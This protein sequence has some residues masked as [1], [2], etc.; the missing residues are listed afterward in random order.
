M[1]ILTN[2][3]TL[4]IVVPFRNEKKILASVVAGHASLSRA[5]VEFLYV[6]D[7][8]T[9]GSGEELR[10]L[11]PEAKI[12]R[13]EG[14]GTGKAFFEGSQRAI[15]TFVL[16]LPMDCLLSPEGVDELL[17]E[18]A[19]DQVRVLLFPK[20]YNR[21]EKMSFYAFLQNLILLKGVKLAS[22]TNGFVLHRNILPIL[23][24]SVEEA[25]LN[26]LELSRNTR[27]EK[28]HVLRNKVSVSARRYEQD[29][30]WRRIV[31]NGLILILW[32]FKL[33]SVQSL[34]QMYKR[35]KNV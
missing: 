28:W 9:D 1:N 4:S 23:G 3:T 20:N 30:T 24:Q 2:V 32:Q 29:G 14:M 7:G 34:H 8:S 22:W 10:R 27:G 15:G 6:D 12:L 18:L 19:L 16:L 17:T 26:D 13:L 31:L 21:A 5:E 25:F 11:D 33:A 35:G